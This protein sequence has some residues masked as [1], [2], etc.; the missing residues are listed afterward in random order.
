MMKFIINLPKCVLKLIDI[1]TFPWISFSD[2]QMKILEI[3]N[4]SIWMHKLQSMVKKWDNYGG[5]TTGHYIY[6]KCWNSFPANYSNARRLAFGIL[7]LFGSIYN[8]EQFFA[9]MNYIKNKHRSRLT[10]E[11]LNAEML[12]KCTKYLH[13]KFD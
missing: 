9:T 11:S 8:C 2:L 7:T 6:G 10:D 4:K 5:N 12:L 13:S 1:Q 3:Q